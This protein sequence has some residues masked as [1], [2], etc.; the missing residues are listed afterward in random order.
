M[1]RPASPSRAGTRVSALTAP[2]ATPIAAATPR[3]PRKPIPE[4]YRPSMAMITVT[5]AI[6]TARPLV[7]M[8]RPAASAGSAPSMICCRWRVV[9]NSA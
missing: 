3:V 6:S 5:A 2:T 7:D 9:R 4:A 1:R 8:V